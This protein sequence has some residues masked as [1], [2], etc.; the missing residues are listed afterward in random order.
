MIVRIN[1]W[2]SIVDEVFTHS[3]R[4]S[5]LGVTTNVIQGVFA[6]E[7]TLAQSI[8]NNKRPEAKRIFH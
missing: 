5:S 3:P 6:K 2:V 4:M 8:H 1:W 7:E